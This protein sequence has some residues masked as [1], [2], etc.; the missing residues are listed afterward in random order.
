MQASWFLD[1][2]ITT[3]IQTDGGKL[4][5]LHDS[6]VARGDFVDV[7]VG[8]KISSLPPFRRGIVLIEFVIKE[9]VV[10]QRQS[11]V[12]ENENSQRW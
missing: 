2:R 1:H 6:L 4:I 5:P 3:K 11:Q 7:L 8:I 10:L 9:V 12:S